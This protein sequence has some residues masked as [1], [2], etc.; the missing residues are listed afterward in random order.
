MKPEQKAGQNRRR[1]R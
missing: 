1:N